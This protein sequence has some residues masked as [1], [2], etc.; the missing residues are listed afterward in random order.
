[1]ATI[2]AVA[3]NEQDSLNGVDEDTGGVVANINL[4]IAGGA[5]SVARAVDAK[6]IVALTESG[7]DGF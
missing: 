6:A 5:V 7:S 2:C 4:A 1:M 3:E